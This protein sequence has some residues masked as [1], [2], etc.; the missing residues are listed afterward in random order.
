MS[1]ATSLAALMRAHIRQLDARDH[2]DAPRMGG[3]FLCPCCKMPLLTVREV[4]QTCPLCGWIDDGQ[5]EA[6][7]DL[8]LPLSPNAQSLSAGRANF[9]KFADVSGKAP[10][11]TPARRAV[12]DYV[13]EVRAGARLDLDRFHGLMGAMDG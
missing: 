6:E 8:D 7:A 3:W 4:E 10:V 1:D 5:D 12:L 13:A 11:M 9:A 2:A